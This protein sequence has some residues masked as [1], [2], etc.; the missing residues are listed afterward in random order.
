MIFMKCER[1]KNILTHLQN[2]G[3]IPVCCGEPMHTLVPGEIDGS[4][5]K[6]VPVIK[7]VNGV[8]DRTF[9]RV[10]TVEVGSEPHP[11]TEAHYV[12]WVI[13][14]TDMGFYTRYLKPND[15]PKVDFRIGPDE[16]VIV[17]YAYCNIHGLWCADI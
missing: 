14:E 5:E 4:L 16:E 7:E 8:Q 15:A 2:S 9:N 1:C 3:V 10:I 12:Q 13:L 17:A 6:H 11:M